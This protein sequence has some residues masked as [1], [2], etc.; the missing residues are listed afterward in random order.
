MKRS[1]DSQAASAAKKPK[2]VEKDPLEIDPL[3]ITEEDK[4]NAVNDDNDD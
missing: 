2:V 3:E 1:A 4:A